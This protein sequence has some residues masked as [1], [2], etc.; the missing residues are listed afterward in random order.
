MQIKI[1]MVINDEHGETTI[2]D[3]IKLE[4]SSDTLSGIGLSL[5]DSKDILKSL[6]NN[7]VNYQAQVY[8]DEHT[9]CPHCEKKRRVKG[10]H[11][12]QY[13]TLFGIVAILSRRVY[14]C[15]CEDA[16][17]KTVSVLTDW[18]TE[19]NACPM[20]IANSFTKTEV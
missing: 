13:R 12:I 11:I 5:E 19:H 9:D 8:T 6:Q 14:R 10:N 1:Q 18:L 3:I 2:E 7:I 17:S 4:K 15:E 20:R 16:D